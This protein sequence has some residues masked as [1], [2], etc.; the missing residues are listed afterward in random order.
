MSENTLIKYLTRGLQASLANTP[1]EDGKLRYTIDTCRLYMDFLDGNTLKRIRINDV[2]FGY[3]ES[4]ILALNSTSEK[5]YI[6]SDTSAAFYNVNG[7]WMRVGGV[8][9]KS[10]STN[11]DYVLWFSSEDGVQPLYNTGL[12]YNPSTNTISVGHV[13]AESVTIGNMIIIETTDAD[14]NHIV[15][16]DF[17]KNKIFSPTKR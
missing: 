4:Q 16:F 9:L 3:T 17:V 15:D 8:T 10:D 12:K 11:K 6:S 13:V 5:I 7:S 14:L 2:E 1:I